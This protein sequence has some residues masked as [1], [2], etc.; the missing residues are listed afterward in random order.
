MAAKAFVLITTSV[1][2]TKS[3]LTALKKLDGIKTVDAVMGP[4]DIIAVVEGE[5][6]DTVGKLITEQFHKISGI[7]R[8]TTCQTIRIA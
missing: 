4:Y 3:V 7:E 8:T 2:Q 1:G 5:S 6:V